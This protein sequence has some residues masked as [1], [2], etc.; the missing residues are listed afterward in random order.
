MFDSDN[1]EDCFDFMQKKW[2]VEYDETAIE[3]GNY[4]GSNDPLS[5]Y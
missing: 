5:G 1:T 3:Q 4:P 2:R